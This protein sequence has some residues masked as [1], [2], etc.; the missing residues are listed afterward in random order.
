MEEEKTK[1]GKFKS[2]SLSPNLEGLYLMCIQSYPVVLQSPQ[3]VESGCDAV[4][5]SV[6]QDCLE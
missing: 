3:V 5:P 4:V 6:K 1:N 2:F